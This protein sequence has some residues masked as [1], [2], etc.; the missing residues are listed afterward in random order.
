MNNGL[1]RY[2]ELSCYVM[3]FQGH[4]VILFYI[5]VPVYDLS[6]IYL[7][8]YFILPIYPNITIYMVSVNIYMY[9]TI[10]KTNTFTI[11]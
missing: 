9:I 4:N 2:D 5:T 3:N 10:V 11:N 1:H 7:C 8:V 6:S